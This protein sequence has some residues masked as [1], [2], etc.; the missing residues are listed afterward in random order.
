MYNLVPRVCPHVGHGG[1]C[2][3]TGGNSLD[4]VERRACGADL[5]QGAQEGEKNLASRTDIGKKTTDT[6]ENS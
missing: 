4:W 6:A 5:G 1:G 2:G 3:G